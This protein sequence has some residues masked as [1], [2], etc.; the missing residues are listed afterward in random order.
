MEYHIKDYLNYIIVER[1]LTT[2]TKEAYETDLFKYSHFLKN[3]R[4]IIEIKDI[5]KKDIILYIEYLSK[6]NLSPKSI[7]RKITAIKNFHKYLLK[8]KIIKHNPTQHIEMPKLGLSLPKSLT[9]ED[10]DKLLN[11]VPLNAYDYRNKAMLELLYATGLRVSELVELKM[12]DINMNMN[13]VRC[14]GKGNK[15]RIIP[16]GDLAIEAIKKY[17]I[18][19]RELLSKNKTSNYLFLSNRGLKISRQGFFKLLKKIALKQGI[20]KSFSPHT[21]RHTFA[22]HLL[23][24]GADLR[25]IQ[26]MLGH[27]DISTTQ[28]YTHIGNELIRKNYEKYHPRSKKE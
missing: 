17:C 4:N 26:E 3:H 7:A 28:I 6:Q 11:I 2:N 22:T 14:I 16:I 15:E 1:K 23:E 5:S 18:N 9:I 27:S 21:L 25:S 19:Y 20:N 10:I 24:Y 13:I 8:E 12:H